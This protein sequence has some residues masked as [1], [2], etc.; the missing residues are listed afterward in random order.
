KKYPFSYQIA[1]ECIQALEAIL[2]HKISK[3]EIS[4]LT[5]YLELA[6]RRSLFD[7]WRINRSCDADLFTN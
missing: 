7:H 1:S 3:V 4:Y 6:F 5:L 2:Q